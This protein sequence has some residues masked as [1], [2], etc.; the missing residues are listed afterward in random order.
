MGG[1]IPWQSLNMM[2][3]LEDGEKRKERSRLLGT[4]PWDCILPWPLLCTF[5][6]WLWGN[7]SF[8][9]SHCYN[10]HFIMGP[11]TMDWMLWN[12]EPKHVLPPLN[13]SHQAVGDSSTEAWEIC[14]FNPKHQAGTTVSPAQ[15]T[16]E[17]LIH[18]RWLCFPSGPH[19]QE[20][21][22][23]CQGS[24]WRNRLKC[25]QDPVHEMWSDRNGQ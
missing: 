19:P 7:P 10:A 21:E 5:F 9:G 4:I 17:P 14:I 20:S 11:E 18:K 1:W 8:P 16:H 22:Q 6:P 3:L 13:C 25:T 15:Q 23:L 2:A 24:C 12:C